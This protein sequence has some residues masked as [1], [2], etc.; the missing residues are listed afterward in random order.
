MVPFIENSRQNK[1]WEENQ[2]LYFGYKFHISIRYPLGDFRGAIGT[3]DTDLVS[4]YIIHMIFKG[5]GL[6]KSHRRMCR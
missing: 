6:E 4:E 5:T 2:E 3:A 1:F